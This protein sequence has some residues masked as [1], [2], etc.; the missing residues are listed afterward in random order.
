[1]L[2]WLVLPHKQEKTKSF[3]ISNKKIKNMASVYLDPCRFWSLASS[4]HVAT[5]ISLRDYVLNME[6]DYF[7]KAVTVKLFQIW[8]WLA[9]TM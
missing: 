9:S 4:L 3:Q 2:H 1:M 7:H 8:F 6:T 5:Q